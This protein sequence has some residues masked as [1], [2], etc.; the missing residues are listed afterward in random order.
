M[1]SRRSYFLLISI[2]LLTFTT[3]LQAKE[4]IA[5]ILSLDKEEYKKNDP[6]TLDLKLKNNGPDP[7]YVNTR[8]YVNSEKSDPKYR[9]VYLMV[10]SPSGERLEYN[11]KDYECGFPKSDYF[12]PLK[13]G[14]EI[15]M[16]HS[17]SLKSYFKIEDIGEYKIQ[18]V[19]HNSYG[20]EIELDTFQ[21][22]VTSN[23]VTI[24]IIE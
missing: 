3:S 10:T 13:P 6:I 4:D 2:F 21:D 1:R 15:E 5:L 24:N 17:K 19:Y 14:E 20:Q 16:K 7:V 9:E 8:F 11:R 23:Q 22:K 12:Q 18:A